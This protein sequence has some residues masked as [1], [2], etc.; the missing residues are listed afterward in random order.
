MFRLASARAVIQAARSHGHG[1]VL[2]L[3][4]AEWSTFRRRAGMCA[5]TA[6]ATTTA[7]Q[8]WRRGWPDPTDWWWLSLSAVFLMIAAYYLRA[9]TG[10]VVI[11]PLGL[12]TSRIVRGRF[13]AW[14]DVRSITERT[15]VGKGGS[16]TVARLQTVHGRTL[17]LPV[18]RT[19]SAL[20]EGA[21]HRDIRRL[22]SH[23][24]AH[25]RHC[26]LDH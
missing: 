24:P 26:N 3:S 2:L 6:L 21:F 11:E 14:S 10:W 18:P 4:P 17:I 15:Y 25:N 20:G 22:Q 13:I 19:V 23:I 8:P 7:S 1:S 5:V 12:R 9:S 16:V